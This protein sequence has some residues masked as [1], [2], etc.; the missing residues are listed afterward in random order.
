MG[1]AGLPRLVEIV[2]EHRFHVQRLMA[3]RHRQDAYILLHHHQPLVLVDQFDIAVS[4]QQVISLRAT[5][6]N[7]HTWFQREVKLRH[8]LAIDTDA[9]PLQRLFHLVTALPLHV[10]KQERE[11]LLRPLHRVAVP[12]PLLR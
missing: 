1:R 4:E 2:V 3:C 9:A 8:R 6:V 7:P 11:Q 12:L 10:L 5:H